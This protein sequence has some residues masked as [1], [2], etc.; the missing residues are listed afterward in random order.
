MKRGGNADQYRR[1]IDNIRTTIPEVAIRTTFIAGFPGK[2]TRILSVL[3]F[4]RDVEFDR[5]GYLHTAMKKARL[6]SIKIQKF[7]IRL[8]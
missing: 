7:R 6:V 2:L 1:M 5:V 8:P 4:V 3:D